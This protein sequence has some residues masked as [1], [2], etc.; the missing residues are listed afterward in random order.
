MQKHVAA[1]LALAAAS[2]SYAAKIDVSTTKHNIA[3]WQ[4]S[5]VLDGQ[6][7]TLPAHYVK[8]TMYGAVRGLKFPFYEEKDIGPNDG[9][10]YAD[11][12]FTLPVGA[13]DAKL[14]LS[15]LI[16]DDRA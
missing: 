11:L 4:A 8:E 14:H 7:Y 1:L 15:S 16:V 2:P 12:F 6:T 5:E 13:T 3:Q 10:W 9:F